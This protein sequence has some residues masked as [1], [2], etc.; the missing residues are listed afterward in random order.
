MRTTLSIA[1]DVLNAAKAM[2]QAEGKTVGDVVSELARRTLQKRSRA[3]A[4]RNGV[5]LLPARKGDALV[6]LE[7][8]NALRDDAR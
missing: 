2:A 8:V 1:D 3:P 6:T 4:S 5:P 7:L